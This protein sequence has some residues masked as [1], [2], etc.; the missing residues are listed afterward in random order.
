MKYFLVIDFETS[1]L[2]QNNGQPI[3]LGAVLLDKADLST[4]AEFQ[5]Y[6]QFDA[7]RFSWSPDAEA[8]HG[9]KRETLEEN[10]LSLSDAWGAFLDWLGGWIDLEEA[11]EVMLCGHTVHFDLRFLQI[12]ADCPPEAD[13][14]PPWACHTVRD[15]L[16]WASLIAQATVEA[17][18]LGAYPFRDP[19][20]GRPSLS[21]TAV[22][23]SL[24]IPTPGAHSAL[25]DARVTAKVM[26][27]MLD[28]LVEDLRNSRKYSR[29]R[30]HIENG[31]Y[32]A[33]PKK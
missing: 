2:P 27:A 20:S 16:Q 21:L 22:A 18:G 13:L 10:G 4:L 7:E 28:H 33:G 26:R 11:G 24:G 3:E 30:E 9:I 6:V 5:I 14:M 32:K 23:D 29:R 25:E 17:H 12:L 19:E 31:K 1:D 8:T 15:S